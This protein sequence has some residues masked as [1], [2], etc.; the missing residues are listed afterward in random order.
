MSSTREAENPTCVGIKLI[1]GRRET[2]SFRS[3]ISM[4]SSLWRCVAYV[5]K[6]QGLRYTWGCCLGIASRAESLRRAT[7]FFTYHIWLRTKCY[8]LSL[9]QRRVQLM[10]KQLLIHPGGRYGC[11]LARGLFA[12]LTGNKEG[13]KQ[14]MILRVRTTLPLF[15]TFLRSLSSTLYLWGGTLRL[16]T[17]QIF[18]GI[19]MS[20]RVCARE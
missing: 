11:W 4:A 17:S 18:K 6:V 9:N 3:A 12:S 13:S 5:P 19:L 14:L 16:P 1:W 10:L 8:L 15:R 2:V 20:L 7:G